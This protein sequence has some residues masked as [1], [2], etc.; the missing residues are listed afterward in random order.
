MEGPSGF[1]A[2]KEPGQVCH[3]RKSLYGLKQS[4]RARFERFASTVQKFELY[5]SKENNLFSF[6]FIRKNEFYS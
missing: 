4:P 1:V 6:D 5:R 2:Q 3:L